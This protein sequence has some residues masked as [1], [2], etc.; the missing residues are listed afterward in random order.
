MRQQPTWSQTYPDHIRTWIT[1]FCHLSN[2]IPPSN[3]SSSYYIQTCHAPPMLHVN[4]PEQ[5]LYT[6]FQPLPSYPSKHS[7]IG[8]QLYVRG[9]LTTISYEV[10]SIVYSQSSQNYTDSSFPYF[11]CY[12][13][14][15]PIYPL[16]V[17][18]V[19]NSRPI[20]THRSHSPVPYSHKTKK[21]RWVQNLSNK[22]IHI[23]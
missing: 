8:P 18:S 7:V 21:Y 2:P 23:S 9:P 22:N 1:I 12:V 15:H 13:L 11:L 14:T 6:M 5:V 17:L 10:T 19:I 20:S 3:F 16:S 4:H